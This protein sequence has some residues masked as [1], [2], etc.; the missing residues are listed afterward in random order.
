MANAV[1][2]MEAVEKLGEEAMGAQMTVVMGVATAV[3]VRPEATTERPTVTVGATVV[4]VIRAVGV[5]R[6]LAARELAARELAARELA[7]R[8]LAARELAAI[9]VSAALAR[10]DEWTV[11]A[12]EREV[13]GGGR[14]RSERR[15][16]GRPDM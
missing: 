2:E 6:E 15:V 13:T 9:T 7:A 14:C 16:G 3:W 10:W 12:G 1:A 8:E 4:V 5:A 11:V